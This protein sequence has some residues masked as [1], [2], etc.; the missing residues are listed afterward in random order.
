VRF[1]QMWVVPDAAGRIPGYEQLELDD[2]VLRNTLAVVASG[3]P[4]HADDAAIRIGNRDAALLVTRLDAGAT[5]TI[6]DAPYVHLFVAD[7]AVAL[8]EAGDLAAGDAVRLT[9]AGARRLT[10]AEPAEVLIWEMYA[11]LAA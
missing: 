2:P 9:G 11:D 1:I 5:V 8:E 3:R 10:A 6:P 7:G 4:E